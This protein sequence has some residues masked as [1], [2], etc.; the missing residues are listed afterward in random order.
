MYSYS[1]FEDIFEISW[2][3]S[4]IGIELTGYQQTDIWVNAESI[5]DFAISFF[6]R[7]FELFQRFNL[8]QK[9]MLY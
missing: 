6:R 3:T 5:P 7:A 9:L 1:S 4:K 2:S 8:L